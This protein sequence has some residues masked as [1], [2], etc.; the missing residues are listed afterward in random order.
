MRNQYPGTCYRCG[1]RVEAWAG[2][3]ECVANTKNWR[4]QHAQCAIKF[5]GTN[6]HYKFNP[7]KEAKK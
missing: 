7:Y 4:V 2:H 3:F 5:R 1:K 6:T